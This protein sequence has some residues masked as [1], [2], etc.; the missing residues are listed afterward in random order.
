ML[1]R[2]PQVDD[3]SLRSALRMEALVDVLFEVHAEGPAAAIAPSFGVRGVAEG[4]EHVVARCATVKVVR[5]PAPPSPTA[6][7]ERVRTE[8]ANHKIEGPT[9][10]CR[11]PENV[12]IAAEFACNGK[13]IEDN[14]LGSLRETC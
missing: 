2:T 4:A 3:V 5:T 6:G 9:S 10:V 14:P 12:K 11:E 13:T 7:V 1:Q 8:R